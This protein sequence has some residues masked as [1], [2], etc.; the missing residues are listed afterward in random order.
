MQ[1]M[2]TATKWAKSVHTCV[3]RVEDILLFAVHPVF[4]MP[5]EATTSPG[6]LCEFHLRE[7]ANK[8][9]RNLFA[10]KWEQPNRA[11]AYLRLV[12]P[13]KHGRFSFRSERRLPFAWRSRVCAAF[14]LLKAKEILAWKQVSQFPRDP[15]REIK[16]SNFSPVTGNEN[17][18]ERSTRRPKFA[19]LSLCHRKSRRC[20]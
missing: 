2:Q 7:D 1:T 4:A 6:C 14:C 15:L 5:L 8:I 18:A 11:N 10:G 20:K 13:R 9:P 12:R 16:K 3:P 19:R 17:R